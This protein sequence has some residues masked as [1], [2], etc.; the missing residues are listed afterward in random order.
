VLPEF[1]FKNFALETLVLVLGRKGEVTALQV[2]S[3][4][5]PLDLLSGER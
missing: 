3:P 2:L 4:S 5:D 1:E